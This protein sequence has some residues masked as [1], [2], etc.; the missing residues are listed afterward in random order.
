MRASPHTHT[1]MHK[2]NHNQFELVVWSVRVATNQN[3]TVFVCFGCC[4]RCRS[5]FFFFSFLSSS[6]FSLSFLFFFFID[7]ASR[8]HWYTL[9][10]LGRRRLDVCCV[11]CV[12]YFSGT[13]SSIRC[14]IHT[15]THTS[16]HV[17]RRTRS[18]Q[19][20]SVHSIDWLEGKKCSCFQMMCTCVWVSEWVF[21]R[22][23]SR[24]STLNVFFS[25]PAHCCFFIF[26]FCCWFVFAFFCVYFI[27]Y[28]YL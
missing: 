28:R 12:L 23:R 25:V 6:S 10:L 18:Y 2:Y 11:L 16:T 14:H 27:P 13:Q 17:E 22:T 9:N 19:V 1:R 8:F 26:F 20:C 4:C 3:P 24:T 7:V 21:V 5:F 15:H